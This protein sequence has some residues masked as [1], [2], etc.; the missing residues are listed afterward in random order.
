M[1]HVE[2]TSELMGYMLYG[3]QSKSK[4]ALDNAYRFYDD[5]FPMGDE[6][7]A[8]IQQ[9]LDLMVKATAADSSATAPKKILTQSWLYAIFAYV[10]SSLR[11]GPFVSGSWQQTPRGLTAASLRRGLHALEACLIEEV[12]LPEDLEKALRG[13]STDLA[14]RAARIRFLAETFAQ[15]DAR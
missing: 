5:D 9:A 6:L 15:S 13:A 2:F 4:A 7:S 8:T 11:P 14:S 3:M 12:D 1:K 10:A